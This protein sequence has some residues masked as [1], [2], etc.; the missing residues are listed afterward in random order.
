M[1]SNIT[2]K[3]ICRKSHNRD[4]YTHVRTENIQKN[5]LRECHAQLFRVEDP[6]SEVSSQPENGSDKMVR[7]LARR[8]HLSNQT[9]NANR[10]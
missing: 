4:R 9:E 6:S 5:K 3:T 2:A 10:K 7:I 1:N 8:A